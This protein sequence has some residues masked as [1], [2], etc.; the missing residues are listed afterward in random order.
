VLI[1]IEALCQKLNIN[2]SALYLMLLLLQDTSGTMPA[3]DITN[4]NTN[5][6]PW[7]EEVIGRR[8]DVVT[9]DSTNKCSNGI[10]QCKQQADS[11]TTSTAVAPAGVM[12]DVT[13]VMSTNSNSSSNRN[14]SSSSGQSAEQDIHVKAKVRQVS[15]YDYSISAHVQCI[16]RWRDTDCVICQVTLQTLVN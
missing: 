9:A 6:M 5:T 15:Y 16:C 11:T 12:L 14:N 1:V 2:T 8:T 13:M 4:T 10:G 7:H 3:T